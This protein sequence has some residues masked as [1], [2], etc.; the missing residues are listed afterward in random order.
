MKL[1]DM[2]KD[3]KLYKIKKQKDSAEEL[4]T[5]SPSCTDNS[6]NRKI[7]Q[8]LPDNSL[9][10]VAF[11]FPCLLQ[12]IVNKMDEFTSL[13]NS[14]GPKIIAITESWY[15]ESIICLHD[16]V[17]Y[18]C[19]RCN[20]TGGGVLLY[21][22]NSLQSVSCTPLNDSNINEAVWCTIQLRNNDQMIVGVVYHSPNSNFENSSKLNQPHSK[23]FRVCWIFSL[24]A[25]GRFQFP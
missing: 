20:T 19:D 3:G 8:T 2:N 16:Y 18:R 17:L 15:N 13:V 4:G 1:K 7:T 6:F 11:K 22:H 21:V 23:D 10:N 12:S 14:L 25:N 5:R 24:L 9:Y